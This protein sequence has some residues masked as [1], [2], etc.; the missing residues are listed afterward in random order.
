MQKILDAFNEYV[1]FLKLFNDPLDLGMHLHVT[2]F[3]VH[4][5]IAYVIIKIAT[6]A[7]ANK[8]EERCANYTGVISVVVAYIITGILIRTKNN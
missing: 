7:E 3:I 8:R 2:I 1:N 5:I 6:R 4:R